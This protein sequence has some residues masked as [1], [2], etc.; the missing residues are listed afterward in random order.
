M[1]MRYLTHLGGATATVLVAVGLLMFPETRTI[2]FLALVANVSSHL[3]VQIL[4]RTVARVRPVDAGGRPLADVAW[5]DPYSFPSG[6]AAAATAVTLTISLQVPT[7]APAL[8]P[9]GALVSLSRVHLKV[10]HLSD[11]VVGVALGTAG[12]LLATSYLT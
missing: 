10:H 9:L 2:G 3:A 12:A 1:I 5:P 11:V 8:L 7:L 4:K 6:H